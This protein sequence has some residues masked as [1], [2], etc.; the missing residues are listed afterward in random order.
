MN[1]AILL[2]N[3]Y[4]HRST[5]LIVIISLFHCHFA[6]KNLLNNKEKHAFILVFILHFI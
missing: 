1:L 5:D 3:L 2:L 4:Y 6:F